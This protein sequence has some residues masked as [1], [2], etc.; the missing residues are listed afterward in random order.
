MGRPGVAKRI[1]FTG[2]HDPDGHKALAGIL[3]AHRD[4]RRVVGHAVARLHATNRGQLA[5][6]HLHETALPAAACVGS[7][8]YGDPIVWGLR[9]FL[10][11]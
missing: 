9:V 3:A 8:G 2:K 6:A 4:G 10:L 1:G 7:A 5:V 11:G